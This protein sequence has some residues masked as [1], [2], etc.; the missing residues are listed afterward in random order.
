VDLLQGALTIVHKGGA[1]TKVTGRPQEWLAGKD[2]K[3]CQYARGVARV[4]R[5]NTER[6]LEVATGEG[7]EYRCAL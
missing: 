5:V 7:H 6:S 2:R 3:K 1:H 4:L